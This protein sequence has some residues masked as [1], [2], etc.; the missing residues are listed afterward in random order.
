MHCTHL[1]TVIFTGFVALAAASPTPQGACFLICAPEQLPCGDGFHPEQQGQC[2]SLRVTFMLVKE[3]SVAGWDQN[4]RF[5][6]WRL[7]F[8]LS[9][10]AGKITTD[11][12]QWL[13]A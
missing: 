13:R 8:R 3:Q 9:G 12:M 10:S 5:S 4:V 2:G 6:G 11:S 1:L 7:F